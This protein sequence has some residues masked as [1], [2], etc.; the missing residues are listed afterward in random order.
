MRAWT[1]LAAGVGVLLGLAGCV[2]P[3]P[4]GESVGRN[5][6]DTGTTTG[7][8]GPVADEAAQERAAEGDAPPTGGI[9]PAASGCPENA[10]G[11]TGA[12]QD[13]QDNP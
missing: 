1:L 12:G 9:D 10:S 8:G 13:L 2:S 11:T 6:P 7:T 5:C 4:Q 3:D